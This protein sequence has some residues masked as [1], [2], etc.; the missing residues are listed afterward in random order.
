MPDRLQ[1]WVARMPAPDPQM[2]AITKAMNAHVAA[3]IRAEREQL[4]QACEAAIQGGVCG[5]LVDETGH[6]APSI[7]VPYGQRWELP[8]TTYDF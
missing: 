7:A 4:E 1:F 3:I 6:A 8:R 2:Q 5:V